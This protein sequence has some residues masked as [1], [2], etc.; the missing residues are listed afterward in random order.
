[1]NNFKKTITKLFTFIYNNNHVLKLFCIY[2]SNL[3]SLK[4]LGG[5]I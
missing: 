2:N 5:F 1:M 4:H 3:E